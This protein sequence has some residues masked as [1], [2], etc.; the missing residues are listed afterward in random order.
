[1]I[2]LT[3][4]VR[5][6][7]IG[8]GGA[9]LSAIARILLA[10]G[11]AVSG[12]D[13]QPG[14]VTDQLAA[15]GAQVFHG[16]RAENVR[17]ADLALATS[18]VADDHIEVVAAEMLGIPVYRRKAFM[19][20]LLRGCDTIAV[21]GTHGKTTTTSMLIHIMESAG[22]SPS[23]IVGGA[24]GNTGK[25]A[26]VGRGDSFVIEADEYDNM[27]HGLA[28][29][30]AVVTN[31]EHDHPDYFETPEQL[32]QAF[33]RFVDLLGSDGVLLACADDPGANA[34]LELR[35]QRGLEARAYAIDAVEA[36]WRA[37]DLDF[38]GPATNNLPS[39]ETAPPWA[40]SGSAYPAGTMCST[41]WPPWPRRM[42]AASLSIKARRR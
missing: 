12:S 21:A 1:M 5:I 26:A 35:R 22:K 25:N 27:F 32:K 14:D 31:V 10:R 30:L 18:A 3:P 40:M 2:P 16:H 29:D 13:L 33:E 6:H 28:P 15:D 34:L 7:I 24:M 4:R 37:T 39:G 9:G 42:N 11:C 17:G 23:Y 8:I 41:R 19:R 36:E 38:A 20:S